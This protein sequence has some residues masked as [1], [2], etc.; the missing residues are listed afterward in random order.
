MGRKKKVAVVEDAQIVNEEIV[1]PVAEET[2]EE[3]VEPVAEV[4]QKREERN[5][6][7]NG[8]KQPTSLQELIAQ[9]RQK[10]EER[11]QMIRERFKQ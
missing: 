8:R 11:R 5:T 3:I 10:R 4:I 6:V 7:A 1:E 9:A 2:K